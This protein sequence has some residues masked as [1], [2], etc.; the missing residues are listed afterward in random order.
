MYDPQT[1]TFATSVIGSFFKFEKEETDHGFALVGYARVLKRNRAVCRAIGELFADGALKFSFEIS[2]GAYTEK[3]DGTV[4]IDRDEN[5]YLEGMCVVSFPACPEAV[6]KMLV[7]ELKNAGQA[8]EMI[9]MDKENE[10]KE[11]DPEVIA[12][13]KPETEAKE[14]ETE[15][16]ETAEVKE[17]EAENAEAEKEADEADA[18]EAKEE[19]AACKKEKAE[20]AVAE[21]ADP[22]ATEQTAEVIQTT[23]HY[24]TESVSTY[25]TE[26]GVEEHVSISVDQWKR[27]IAE[28]KD[29]ISKLAETQAKLA[30]AL[31]ELK[32]PAEEEDRVIAEIENS[33]HK[34]SRVIGE[35]NADNCYRLLESAAGSTNYRL[36]EE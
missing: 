36:L 27:E 3:E 13:T 34:E 8:K 17:A 15:V 12:E 26:T 6:A 2:C 33:D 24:E 23:E 5:N 4:E 10:V 29:A 7:A 1:D 28:M 25:D 30:E 18:K 22:A 11:K 31:A 9:D 20:E 35:M 21:E 19:D 32:K 16:A 14:P